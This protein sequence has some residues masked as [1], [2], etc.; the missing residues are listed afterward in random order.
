ML[1][2]RRKDIDLYIER[3][4]MSITDNSINTILDFKNLFIPK[5][6]KKCDEFK[7]K[8]K[9]F[10]EEILKSIDHSDENNI[11]YKE[12]LNHLHNGIENH[13]ENGVLFQFNDYYI[14]SIRFF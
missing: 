5:F 9:Q 3:K 6:I 7:I 2:R 14:Y 10:T 8:S 12:Y 1:K 11:F 4:K 13:F